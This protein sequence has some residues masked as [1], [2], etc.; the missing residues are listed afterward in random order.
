MKLLSLYIK[1][2]SNDFLITKSKCIKNSL[3]LSFYSWSFICPDFILVSK[4]L[5]FSI[6]FLKW[7]YKFSSSILIKFLFSLKIFRH[8]VN[9]VLIILSS[10][11]ISNSS[12][13]VQ[14]YNFDLSD[15]YGSTNNFLKSCLW[16][17][18]NTVDFNI[19]YTYTIFLTSFKN[20][21]STWVLLCCSFWTI[22]DTIF[23]T[24]VNEFPI[25]FYIIC[26]SVAVF[27]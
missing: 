5:R 8:S 1:P 20:F 7:L 23:D 21:L 18:V 6:Y 3:K 11:I 10:N 13:L 24:W 15:N 19:D 12:M 17:E 14:L 16:L 9:S 4:S 27:R 22:C 25:E 2:L 26:F